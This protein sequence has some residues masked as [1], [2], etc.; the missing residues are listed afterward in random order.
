MQR[1]LYLTMDFDWAADEVLRFTLD[2]LERR[3]PAESD[4]SRLFQ[5]FRF[6]GQ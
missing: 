1:T 5:L 6:T 3:D 2:L 4:R